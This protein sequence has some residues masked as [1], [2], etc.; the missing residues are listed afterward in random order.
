VIR[1][2]MADDQALIRSGLRT[3]LER[4]DD[5][6]VVGEAADGEQA[7][8]LATELRP[9]IVLMDI[10]MPGVDGLAAAERILAGD[11]ESAPRVL[12]LTT[13][14]IDDYVQ[15]ALRTGV[16][17]FLLKDTEP[18]ALVAAVRSA[19]RGDA[20]LSPAVTRRLI[21]AYVQRPAPSAGLRVQL[22]QRESDVLRAMA[23]GLSNAEIGT[24]LYLSEATVKTHITSI[25]AKLGVRDR[26]Q[27]VVVAYESGMVVPGA[28]GG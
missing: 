26:L 23:R 11:R 3:I 19:A 16:T 25:L 12:V 27:A 8:R 10:R 1:I 20:M 7:V 17:G 15:T 14:E 4:E 9:D 6:E 13:F 2:V 24:E 18:P 22:T 28:A 21:E 5:L